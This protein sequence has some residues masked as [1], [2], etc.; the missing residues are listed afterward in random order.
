MKILWIQ[1]ARVVQVYRL[2]ISTLAVSISPPLLCLQCLH[3]VR[4]ST[5]SSSSS[6]QVVSSIRS[7]ATY[8]FCMLHTFDIESLTSRSAMVVTVVKTPVPRSRP[9]T[10][11]KTSHRPLRM[12]S[13]WWERR[14]KVLW[15]RR[16]HSSNEDSER[17]REGL[18]LVHRSFGTWW[19][20]VMLIT[21]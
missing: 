11:W 19:S 7:I 18:R 13:R 21:A 14:R 17:A 8:I 9:R 5:R 2:R 10:Q 3:E 20:W 16:R 6:C 1:N 15:E 12:R 4:N